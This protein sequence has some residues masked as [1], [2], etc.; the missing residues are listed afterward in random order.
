MLSI[1]ASLFVQIPYKIALNRSMS[2]LQITVNECG[3][4]HVSLFSL[5]H[6]LE[7]LYTSNETRTHEV[8]E[9]KITNK[10]TTT[11]Q[12]NFHQ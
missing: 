2:S 9:Y 6:T 7:Q 11:Q 1:I 10:I 3:S 12:K 8:K 5:L 4:K